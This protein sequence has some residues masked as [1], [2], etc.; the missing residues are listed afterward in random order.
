[1]TMLYPKTKDEWLALRRKYV[2]STESAAL[3][4]M[5]PYMT[6]Y[7]LAALKMKPE[8]DTFEGNERTEWGT[9]LQLAVAKKIAADYGVK[10]RA[11]NGY[12]TND[13][14]RMGASFDYEIIGPNDSVAVQD[15]V[16]RRM[17]TEHGV[18]V[19]EIKTV[20]WLVF[21]D[22]WIDGE[23]PAHIEIQVQHQLE[24]I[25]REWAAIGVLVGGN[26]AEV[27]VRERDRDV[28]DAIAFKTLE[29]WTG[30]DAGQLPPVKLPEDIDIL[31][32]IYGYAEPGKVI[33]GT[34]DIDAAAL[35]YMAAAKEVTEAEKAKQAAKGQLL[36]L[37]GDAEKVVGESYSISAGMI[38]E[39]LVE[40]Y[41]RKAYRN[42]RITPKKAKSHE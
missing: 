14:A 11:I 13:D 35:E 15:D 17:Y 38:G 6:A 5:S 7:E 10:V 1:M 39:T 33:K 40:A 23:P 26:R 27:I 42:F 41:T 29:F 8:L 37:I 30:I 19:L 2:S 22:Q 3:F 4:S 31:T 9:A 28:G 21:R 12:K 32:K 18:G 24:C 25:E 20:D 36:Q 16:L 34:A